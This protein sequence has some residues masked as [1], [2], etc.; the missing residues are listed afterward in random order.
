VPEAVSVDIEEL[1]DLLES[2]V[3]SNPTVRGHGVEDAE[4]RLRGR[5]EGRLAVWLRPKNPEAE[6]RAVG[7][8]LIDKLEEVR[9]RDEGVVVEPPVPP[10]FHERAFAD[11]A[12]LDQLERM[13]CGEELGQFYFDDEAALSGDPL[14][15]R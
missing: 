15:D 13:L 14:R 1:L 5:G 3:A 2:W 4:L 7:L 10:D 9:A 8:Y 12:D 11:F 6:L